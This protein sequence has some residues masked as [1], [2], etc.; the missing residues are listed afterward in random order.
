MVGF[1]PT[2][3]ALRKRCSTVELHRRVRSVRDGCLRGSHPHRFWSSIPEYTPKDTIYVVPSALLRHRLTT[4]RRIA[5]V[6]PFISDSPAG[7]N[8]LPPSEC[9]RH[10]WTVRSG[11]QC[12]LRRTWKGERG[13]VFMISHSCPL[14]PAV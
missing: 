3:P 6:L 9:H 8:S 14:T 13:V 4:P 7:V 10:V 2:T 1:E 5:L 11:Q 12:G